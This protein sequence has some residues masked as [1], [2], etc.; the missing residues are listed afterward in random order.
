MGRSNSKEL[1]SAAADM[2]V[3]NSNAIFPQQLMVH[4]AHT[5]RGEQSSILEVIY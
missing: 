4:E 3:Q 5:D 2:P 1:A